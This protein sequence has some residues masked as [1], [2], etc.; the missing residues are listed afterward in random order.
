MLIK[1]ENTIELNKAILAAQSKFP[2]I[3]KTKENDFYRKN[4]RGS[5]YAAYDDVYA[6]VKPILCDVGLIVEHEHKM[7]YKEVEALVIVRQQVVETGEVLDKGSTKQIDCTAEVV[8]STTI[9]HAAS[10]QYK[11]IT[12]STFPDKTSMHGVMAAVT[13][14]KRYN[15][16]SILDIAVCE[17]DDDGNGGLNPPEDRYE[18]KNTKP[19]AQQNGNRIPPKQTPPKQEPKN[20]SAV[21][22]QDL[23][24]QPYDLPFDGNTGVSPGTTEAAPDR[25]MTDTE[26]KRLGK[27]DKDQ[28]E[29]LKAILEKK[30][31]NKD[32]WKSWLFA[33]YSFNSITDITNDVYAEICRVVTERP[34]AIMTPGAS[35]K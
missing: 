10:G 9:I 29:S 13:Y 25:P 2:M 34:D 35:T 1:S 8:V 30:G 11:T 27:V 3:G 23:Q 15:L 22:Q 16:T 17:E 6:G 14:L 20:M 5:K 31:I 7:E 26:R 4:G 28:V 12:S 21:T 33:E 32:K 24:P 18:R 19:P